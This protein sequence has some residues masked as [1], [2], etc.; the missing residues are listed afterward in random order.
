MYQIHGIN[1]S[2]NTTKCVFTAEEL[3]IEYEYINLDLSKG[4]HK[5][6]EHMARHPLGKLPTL[7]HSGQSIF[8]SGAI[9]RYLGSVEN[10]DMYP[11]DDHLARA[12]IDQ[13]MD[14]FSNHVGRWLNTYT[15]ETVAKVK[16]GFG[17]PNQDTI[18]EAAGFLDQQ[19]PA[20]ETHLTSCR[21]FLGDK[22]TIADPFAFA[23]MEMAE[24]GQV[25][26]A[27]YPNLEKWV[28][29]YKGRNS[30]SRAKKCL[31]LA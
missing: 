10:S 25:P 29:N 18:D 24:L 8:E 3:G 15:F 16:Y 2:S 30:V 17:T 31:G 9:C 14:F 19:M 26:M 5:S 22:L 7:T 23:Y 20:V 27:N 13:W 21:Y 28:E 6:P 4:E 11:M 1:F 12:R